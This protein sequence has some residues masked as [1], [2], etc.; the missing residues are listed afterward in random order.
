[1][2]RWIARLE[3]CSRCCG[4]SCLSLKGF[5]DPTLFITGQDVLNDTIISNFNGILSLL[6]ALV[7]VC[8]QLEF[9]SPSSSFETGAIFRRFQFVHFEEVVAQNVE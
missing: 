3:V 1:M 9:P 4:V 8:M 6:F 2:E 7:G 5:Q